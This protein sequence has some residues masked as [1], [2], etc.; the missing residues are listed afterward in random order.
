LEKAGLSQNTS[1]EKLTDKEARTKPRQQDG[2]D[3]LRLPP[4]T[5]N[6]SMEN[7]N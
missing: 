2:K 7:G 5:V 4:L 3:P 1:D 6:A